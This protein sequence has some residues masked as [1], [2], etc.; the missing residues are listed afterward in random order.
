MVEKYSINNKILVFK[1]NINKHQEVFIREVLSIYNEIKSVDFDFEDC[2]NILRVEAKNDIS[3][4][5]IKLLNSKGVFCK[6]LI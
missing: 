3:I 1:T 2:D 5:I 4:V 6:E